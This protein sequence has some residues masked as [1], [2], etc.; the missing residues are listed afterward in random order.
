[1]KYFFKFSG[2]YAVLSLMLNTLFHSSVFAN[3]IDQNQ[4]Y[5]QQQRQAE[6]QQAIIPQPSIFTTPTS[7][8]IQYAPVAPT[9]TPQPSSSQQATT[10]L[11]T[12]SALPCFTI[13]NINFT[14]LTPTPSK[15]V[16]RFYFALKPELLGKHKR[17]GQCLNLNDIESIA[18][19]V[20]N[21]ILEKGFITTRVVIG[22]QNLTKGTLLLTLIIGYVDQIHAHTQHSKRTIYVSKTPSLNQ[23]QA[24]PA[25]YSNALPLT[26]G[27]ILNLRDLETGLENL[28]RVPTVEANFSIQPSAQRDIPGLSDILIQYSAQKRA[29][30]HFNIDNSGSKY[31]GKHQGSAT[32]SFLNPTQHNDLLYLNYGQDLRKLFQRNEPIDGKRGSQNWSMGYVL[33]INRWLLNFSTSQY[34]YHQTVVGVNQD[35]EYSGTSQ[36]SSLNAQY[37]LH[38]NQNSKTYLTAGGYSKTQNNF[39]DDTE[40]D[41]QRRKTAG[42]TAGIKHERQFNQTRLITDLTYQRGTGAFNA[43]PPAESL[44]NEGDTRTGVLKGNLQLNTPFKIKEQPFQY[45]LDLKA[46]YA[47][48]SLVPS[49]RMSIGGRYSVHGFDGERTLA[50]DSGAILRQELAWT[51][52]KATQHNAHQLYLGLDAGYVKMQNPQQ[53]QALAGHHLVGSALGLKGQYKNVYYDVFTSYPLY[54]PNYFRYD[55][56]KQ[57]EIKEIVTGFSLGIQF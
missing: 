45:Q 35:Y 28:K 24:I 9:S 49:E 23:K 43:I 6:L 11:N 39:I 53:D 56:T 20:Q 25:T 14:T 3:E 26:S 47:Q 17:I 27:K 2:V 16:Y 8:S 52:P 55:T 21:R 44:F 19:R 42:W 37:L 4:I 54:Q 22:N 57:K 46:Q 32:L 13:H 34:D 29:S 10:Q 36:Q 41:V 40:I 1:M 38:R 18:N 12:S 5:Y 50:G 51:L 15:D 33:P 30:I 48:Q 7:E 31:T